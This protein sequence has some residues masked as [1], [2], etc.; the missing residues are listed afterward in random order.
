MK[1]RDVLK[2]LS[3]APLGILP[4][5]NKQKKSKIWEAWGTSDKALI[6]E[7]YQNGPPPNY[8]SDII[9]PRPFDEKF[10]PQLSEWKFWKTEWWREIKTDEHGK[11]IWETKEVKPDHHRLTLAEGKAIGWA[12]YWKREKDIYVSKSDAMLF[13]DPDSFTPWRGYGNCHLIQHR[14]DRF[15]FNGEPYAST[16]GPISIKSPQYRMEDEEA[17][18][19]AKT[20]GLD[21]PYKIKTNER[22][23]FTTTPLLARKS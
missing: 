15:R 1:R 20:L 22:T 16:K 11:A 19:A 7:L 23:K 2:A 13:L 6:K 21:P 10:G 9:A 3:L 18:K 8:N 14:Y 17:I 5:G 4:F 12:I